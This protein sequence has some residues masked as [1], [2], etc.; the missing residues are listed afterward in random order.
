MEHATALERFE[1]LSASPGDAVDLALGAFLISA[2]IEP[3]VDTDAELARLDALADAARPRVMSAD[4][5][6]AQV[7]ALNDY[8]FGELGFAGNQEDY[9]D[10]RNSLLHRVLE[11]RV[12]IPITLSL[13]YVE[14]GARLG[15][16]LVGIGMPGHFL[17]GHEA[18]AALYIDPLYGGVMLS[19]QE[20]AERL[21]QISNTVHWDRTFLAPVSN[22]AFLARIL[23]NLSAIWLHRRE[24]EHAECMLSMLIALQPEEA[25]HRRDRGM[26]RHRMGRDDQAL[27]DL[28]RYMERRPAAPDSWYVRRLTAQIR[29][30][31]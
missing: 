4:G 12:G 28:D 15:V 29:G 11:R 26:L 17:V 5:P 2:A 9:Y 8:L 14:V 23:R 20:C 19:E 18:E 27:E 6:L 3:E 1:A 7:N 16:P 30:E 24:L 10:P 25:G 22:R 21:R 31:A 13:L